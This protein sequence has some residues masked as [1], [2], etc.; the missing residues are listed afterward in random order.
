MG[1]LSAGKKIPG[2]SKGKS[3]V[4]QILLEDG[5]NVHRSHGTLS[6]GCCCIN[7]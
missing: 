7:N 1:C 2:D 6:L 4:G 3:N 5:L